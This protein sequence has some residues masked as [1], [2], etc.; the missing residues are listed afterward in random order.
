[1]HVCV[2]VWCVWVCV[3]VCVCVCVY[4]CVSFCMCMPACTHMHTQTNSY[5]QIKMVSK[6]LENHTHTPVELSEVSPKLPLEPFQCWFHT[7]E[8]PPPSLPCM[9]TRTHTN[10]HTHHTHMQTRTHTHTHTAL[11]F[12]HVHTGLGRVPHGIHEDAREELGEDDAHFGPHQLV[13]QHLSQQLRCLLT[14]C[15]V[16]RI[17]EQVQQVDQCSWEKTPELLPCSR[18]KCVHAHIH[19]HTHTNIHAHTH[20]QGRKQAIMRILKKHK[21]K[22]MTQKER[23]TDRSQE[24]PL[25]LACHV[26]SFCERTMSRGGIITSWRHIG[27]MSIWFFVLLWLAAERQ[28]FFGCGRQHCYIQCLLGHLPCRSTFNVGNSLNCFLLHGNLGYLLHS[29]TVT[30]VGT[31]VAIPGSHWA[32]VDR[33]VVSTS[34]QVLQLTISSMEFFCPVTCSLN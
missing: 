6:S 22:G 31:E 23:E 1:M 21:Q 26:M 8:H 14:H 15:R 9:H 30:F 11:T 24:A 27:R 2:C 5:V 17:A 18:W 34:G 20:T 32:V 28:W 10:T 33:G 13:R 29:S 4:V 3:C 19:P 7:H 12:K 16:C 25:S